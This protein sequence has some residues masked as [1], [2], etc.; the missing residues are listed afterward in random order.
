MPWEGRTATGNNPYKDCP[1]TEIVRPYEWNITRGIIAPDG[2]E[3][4]VI[5]VNG[6]YPGP[7]VEANWGDY[8]E[9]KVNNMID[10][11]EEGTA[12]HWHGFMQEGTPWMDGVPGVSQCPI[13]PSKSF[14]YKFQA[15]VYGSSWY[16]SHY[17]AQYS[18]GLYGPIVVHGPVDTKYDID[19]GPIL[20]NGE[21]EKVF[22]VLPVN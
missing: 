5:L 14:T 18:G 3:K 2:Y 17:S 11:V 22:A 4:K 20:V 19:V 15:T 9:V 21:K 7:L 10:D 16:H 13:A 8:I 1:S 6:Q 12:I